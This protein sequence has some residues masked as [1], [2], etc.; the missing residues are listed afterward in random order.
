MPSSCMLCNKKLGLFSASVKNFLTDDK[1]LKLCADCEKKI[2]KLKEMKYSGADIENFD[3]S[4]FSKEGAEI[5]AEFIENLPEQSAEKENKESAEIAAEN[6][7]MQADMTNAENETSEPLDPMTREVG[8]A[9][10]DN[11]FESND[12]VVSEV[13][14]SL[15]GLGEDEIESFL[16]GK[17]SEGTDAASFCDEVMMLNDEE[18]QSVINDQ[19]E[20]YN[21]AEWAYI[22]YVNEVRESRG[23]RPQEKSKETK[24]I[25]LDESTADDDAV[26]KLMEVHADKSQEELEEI[27]NDESYTIDARVAAKRLIEQSKEAQD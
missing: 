13:L 9:V 21:D 5:A 3:Y 20:Y 6:E 2:E 26:E 16:E 14:E 7:E 22:L 10:V 15:K 24:E 8:E 18:L 11:T 17:L 1:S 27:L 23:E 19:R 12:E 4:G 25:V